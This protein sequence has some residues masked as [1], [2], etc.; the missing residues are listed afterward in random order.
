MYTNDIARLNSTIGNINEY[1][2]TVLAS[3]SSMDDLKLESCKAYASIGRAPETKGC[4]DV[5]ERMD[6]H[7]EEDI[8]EPIPGENIYDGEVTERET[9]VLENIKAVAPEDE[10]QYM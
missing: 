8:Y 3:G 9:I 2:E 10:D 1:K 5:Y 4:D 7:D 6:N